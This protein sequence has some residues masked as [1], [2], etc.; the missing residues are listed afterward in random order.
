MFNNKY[1]KQ[2]DGA[3]MGSLLGSA[4]ANIFICRFES[5]QPRDCPSDFKPVFYRRQINDIV[6]LFSSR[7]HVDK[8]REYLSSRHRN[9]NFS[10]EKEEDCCLPFLDINIFRENDKFATK[11]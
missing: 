8:F 9:I 2:M 1:Y 4:L 11:V 6:V 5:R 10:I 7:D 3:A